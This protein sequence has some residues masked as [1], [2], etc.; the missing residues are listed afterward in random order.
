MVDK[1]FLMLPEFNVHY[2]NKKA[3]LKEYKKQLKA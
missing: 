3:A 1:L 2:Y